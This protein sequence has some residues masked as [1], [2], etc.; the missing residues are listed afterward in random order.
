MSSYKKLLDALPYNAMWETITDGFRV[1]RIGDYDETPDILYFTIEDLEAIDIRLPIAVRLMIERDPIVL[2]SEITGLI[3]AWDT[4]IKIRSS[5]GP[6]IA[7]S[8]VRDITVNDTTITFNGLGVQLQ[9]VTNT[10]S[11]ETAILTSGTVTVC[12]SDCAWFDEQYPEWK[13][14]LALGQSLGLDAQETTTWLLNAE[15]V[16]TGHTLPDNLAQ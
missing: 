14:R 3:L 6:M 16:L 2:K 11:G 9:E 10:Q 13:T 12:E 1:F 4:S 5:A 7:M 8:I 15:H